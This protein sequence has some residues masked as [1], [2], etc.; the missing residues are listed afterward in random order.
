M[1]G[2]DVTVYRRTQSG[3]DSMGEPLYAWSAETVSN[4]L[5]NVTSGSDQADEVRPDG[6]RAQCTVA[7]PKAYT[8][9][10]PVGY[11]DH[12]RVSITGR[13]MAD[14]ADA[15]LIVSG[16]PMRTSPCP[17]AWDTKLVCGRMEG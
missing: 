12:A 11:F 13:G 7:L 15:A 17:T 14:D 16:S 1:L 10:K 4:C 6:I 2:E 8:E 3:A 5:V 9:G